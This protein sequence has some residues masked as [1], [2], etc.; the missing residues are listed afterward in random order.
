MGTPRPSFR[1]FCTRSETNLAP[2]LCGLFV[3]SRPCTCDP[4]T[5]LESQLNAKPDIGLDSMDSVALMDRFDDKYLIPYAWL[6]D[7]IDALPKFRVLRINDGCMTRYNNLYFDTQDDRCFADHVRGKNKRFKVRIRHYTNTDVAFLEVKLRDVYGKTTKHRVSRNGQ[8]AWNAPLTKEETRFLES[9]LGQVAVALV[10]VLQSRFDRFTLA[11]VDSGERVT[12]DHGLE[13]VLP[14]KDLWTSP[15]PN[16][17]VV[18]RKQ[19]HV[20]HQGPLLH[21]FRA[22][23][24]RRA[25]LGR[26]IRM[27]K[28]VLGR[29]ST[30]P[31]LD[32]KSYR[33]GLRDIRRAQTFALN[34]ELTQN[35]LLR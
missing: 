19:R 14:Q 26:S 24:Q 30:T 16:L 33:S 27:S 32:A 35:H 11:D 10:P 29:L 3:P 7:V 2:S 1:V 15:I 18:E 31:E 23:K 9:H 17:V 8:D 34:P 4:M 12:M 5:T 21:S 13:F 28:F 20:N 22:Q 25:P 6:P